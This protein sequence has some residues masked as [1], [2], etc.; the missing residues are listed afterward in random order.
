MERYEIK[1]CEVCKETMRESESYYNVC[2]E[3]R[4]DREEEMEKEI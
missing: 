1:R 2:E 4:N 3:C